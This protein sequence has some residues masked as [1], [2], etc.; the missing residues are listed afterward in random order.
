MSGRGDEWWKTRLATDGNSKSNYEINR[1][2]YTAKSFY[3]RMA[4]NACS[5]LGNQLQ[6]GL[7]GFFCGIQGLKVG[8]GG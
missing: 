6:V 5:I 2:D 8:G 4:I 1:N 7:I 3:Y